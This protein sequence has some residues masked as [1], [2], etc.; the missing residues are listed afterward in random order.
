M[1]ESS[2]IPKNNLF[3]IR[4]TLSNEHLVFAETLRDWRDPLLHG[5]EPIPL[6]LCPRCTTCKCDSLKDHRSYHNY[7]HNP[8]CPNLYHQHERTK[9]SNTK[10]I[11]TKF[12]RRAISHDPS[13]RVLNNSSSLSSSIIKSK[14][15]EHSPLTNI[16]KRKKLISKIPVR[17]SPSP[18]SEYSPPSSSSSFILNRSSKIPRLILTRSLPSP[19]IT[20]DDLYEVDR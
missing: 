18:T 20:I 9:S 7:I 3:N 14:S 6:L 1:A 2:K 12:K 19:T 8:S 17:I 13:I 5:P 15:T 16:I 11:I 4:S 10:P